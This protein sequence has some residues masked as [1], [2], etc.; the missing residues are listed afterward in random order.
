MRITTT[1]DRFVPLALVASAA[2]ALG[3][4]SPQ[5][6]AAMPPTVAAP[7][8]V[9]DASRTAES[10]D[11][12]GGA[13]LVLEVGFG[14]AG[15]AAVVGLA[16]TVAANVVHDDAATLRTDTA[17]AGGTSACYQPA[18]SLAQSCADLQDELALQ[19]RLV[20]AA[21][22]FWIVSGVALV[23]TSI[24]GTVALLSAH[25]HSVQARVVP[26]VGPRF[27]GLGVRGA[28]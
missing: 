13:A 16:L 4:L 12:D 3:T 10:Q 1:S 22:P 18:E 15:A 20:N 11:G 2:L 7:A 28:F 23:G 5:L 14:T 26:L 6:G 17:A 8:N 9:E 27:G 24:F 21:I 19:D 25:E